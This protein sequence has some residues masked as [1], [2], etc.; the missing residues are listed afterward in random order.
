MNSGA[1]YLLYISIRNYES[2]NEEYLKGVAL[3]LLGR[4]FEG[5]IVCNNHNS[6]SFALDILYFGSE[7]GELWL[8]TDCHYREEYLIAM[9]GAHLKELK[10]D[11]NIVIDYSVLD[12]TTHSV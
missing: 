11:K 4:K 3:S 1:T 7:K 6:I 2:A 5:N 12:L 9:I 8:Y 10:K